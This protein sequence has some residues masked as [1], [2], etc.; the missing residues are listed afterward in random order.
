M[1]ATVATPDLE[2]LAAR[3]RA[4]APQESHALAQLL[5]I[6]RFGDARAAQVEQALTR[7]LARAARGERPRLG[8]IRRELEISAASV[9][10]R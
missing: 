1:S 9:S 8:S 6:A 5:C 4:L 3:V 2:P 7:F 10:D